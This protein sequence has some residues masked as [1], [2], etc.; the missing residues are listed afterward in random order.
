[1]SSSRL[2]TPEDEKIYG[3]IT[4]KEFDQKRDHEIRFMA[5]TYG[6]TRVLHIRE[7]FKMKEVEEWSHG[8]GVTFKVDDLPFAKIAL[9]AMFEGEAP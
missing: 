2:P 5:Q 7:F 3:R 6:G 9:D 4:I 1:M 8:K